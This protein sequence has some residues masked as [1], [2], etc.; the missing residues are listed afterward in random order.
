MGLFSRKKSDDKKADQTK[1]AK[2]AAPKEAEVQDEILTPESQAK[3]PAKKAKQATPTKAVKGQAGE[4][5]R[6]L[7]SPKVSEK[8]ADLA[9][10]NVYVFNVPVTAEKVAIA[11]AVEK[12]Y[13][14][15]VVAVRTARGRGKPVYRGYKKGRR[16][17]WKKAFVQVKKGQTIDLYEGV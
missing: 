13:G 8:V 10:K 12:L 11:N 3:Q 5:Y 2:Q 7:L 6:L 15:K 16:N 14:V 1:Q 4:S 17:Q 9:Q